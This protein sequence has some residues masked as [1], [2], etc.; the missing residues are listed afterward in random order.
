MMESEATCTIESLTTVVAELDVAVD[1][2]VS[3]TRAVLRSVAGLALTRSLSKLLAAR[4]S[5]PNPSGVVTGAALVAAAGPTI[6][7]FRPSLGALLPALATPGLVGLLLVKEV[8]AHSH[9]LDGAS[10]Q[11]LNLID[12][13]GQRNVAILATLDPPAVCFE[14]VGQPSVI[15]PALAVLNGVG[16]AHLHGAFPV[17]LVGISNMMTHTDAA[18][19]SAIFGHVLRSHFSDGAGNGGPGAAHRVVVFSTNAA[20]FRHF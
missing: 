14:P 15:A 1:A 7:G 16:V 9:Q 12:E 20:G 19:D 2:S 17:P 8:C 3:A 10:H 4:R 11:V 18:H 5:K 13:L 6:V